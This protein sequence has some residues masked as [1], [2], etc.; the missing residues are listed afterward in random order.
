MV[1]KRG[2][3]SACETHNK[4]P[5]SW[6]ILATPIGFTSRCWAI[7]MDRMRNAAYF[8]QPMGARVGN[9]SFIKTSTQAPLLWLCTHP[10]P[11]LFTPSYGRLDKVHGKTERGKDQAAVSSN[12]RTGE[13]RGNN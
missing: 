10:S 6:L 5:L 13:Q 12:R 7:R 11:Q 2:D 8:A 3:I 4:L 1:V 9:A